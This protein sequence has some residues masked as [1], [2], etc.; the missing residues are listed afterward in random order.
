MGILKFDFGGFEGF[1]FGLGGGQR[2]ED[3]KLRPTGSISFPFSSFP[4]QMGFRCRLQ[5][6]KR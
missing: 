2:K 4:G 6:F 3:L 1:G 5:E